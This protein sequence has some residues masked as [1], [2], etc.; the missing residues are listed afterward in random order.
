LIGEKLV[1]RVGRKGGDGEVGEGVARE[2]G[3]VHLVKGAE[4]VPLAFGWLE[5]EAVTSPGAEGSGEATALH[6][7]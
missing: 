7:E 6:G 2:G 4:N 5:S 1:E 3:E